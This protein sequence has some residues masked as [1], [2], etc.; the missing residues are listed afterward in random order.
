[1]THRE[2]SESNWLWRKIKLYPSRTAGLIGS[3]V[4]LAIGFGLEITGEQV[5]LIMAFVYQALSWLVER[6]VSP[7]TKLPEI[8]GEDSPLAHEQLT[9]PDPSSAGQDHT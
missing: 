2:T 6:N 4:A 8:A 7:I 1:M 5:S 3:V 9:S